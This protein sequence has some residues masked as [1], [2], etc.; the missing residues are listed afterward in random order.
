LKPKFESQKFNLW[1]RMYGTFV[2]PVYPGNV[3][4]I[5]VL[6]TVSVGCIHVR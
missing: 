6:E 3:E 5:A 2:E 1:P 4:P